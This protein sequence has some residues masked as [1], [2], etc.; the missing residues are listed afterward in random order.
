MGKG[1]GGRGLVLAWLG[2]AAALVLIGV[3]LAQAPGSGSVQPWHYSLLISAVLALALVLVLIILARR[4]IRQTENTEARLRAILESARDAIVIFDANRRIV[5]VNE[6]AERMFGYRREELIGQPAQLLVPEGY[7]EDHLSQ[8]MSWLASPGIAQSLD[9]PV[10]VPSQR[11]DGSRFPAEVSL[12]PAET[13]DGYVVTCIIRDVSERK[14]AA[15]ALRASEEHLRAVVETTPACIKIVAADGTLLDM[16]SAGLAMIDAERPEDVR[17]QCVYNLVAPEY[18]EAFRTLHQRVC[19]GE[20]GW[21]EF[22]VIGLRGSRRYMETHAVP[23]RGPGGASA[24]LAITYDITERKRAEEALCAS[25]E[26]YRDLFENANDIIYTHDLEGNFTSLNKAGEL[27]TGYTRAEILGRM[28]LR[29]IVAP[30][31]LPRALAMLED[32]L[33]HGRPSSRYEVTIVTKSGRRV[34]LEVSNR[35]IRQN[36]RPVGVQGIARDVTAQHLLEE[37]LRQSQK[38][39]AIGRLA[40][41]VAHDF[42]NLLTAIIGWS[43]LLLDD[44]PPDHPSRRLVEDISQAG[45]RAAALTQQLLGFSRKQVVAPTVLDLNAAVRD[46]QALLGRLIREDV[47]LS[48]DLAADIPPVQADPAQVQQV[49]LNLAVNARDAMPQGGR[50]TVATRAVRLGPSDRPGLAPGLY[51]VLSVSDTGHGMTEEVRAHLFEPFF[52]TKEKGKGTGLGLATVYGIV[53]GARGA[54]FV[55]TAV[56]RGTVFDIY[57]PAAPAGA[58]PTAAPAAPAAP[59]RGQET[60]LLVEDEQGVRQ[61]TRQALCL[62]GY[63]VLEASHP[64]EAL[65]IESEYD[66]PIHLLLTDVVMPGMNGRQLADRLVDLRPDLKVLYMS[67]YAD[68]AL[69]PDGT[70]GRELLAK[71]FTPAGLVRKVREVLDAGGRRGALAEATARAE[72]RPGS[73]AANGAKGTAG[74]GLI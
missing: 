47:E 51:A 62:Q 32:K 66:G 50:L 46:T 49:L 69:G 64:D 68:E 1:W 3:L 53:Q 8:S 15:D 44:M 42:N 5:L 61:L 23:L 73:P 7:L 17:G 37:R 21:L 28:N 18:R 29:D 20:R 27:V 74:A 45:R 2:A 55:E 67:G 34:T 56:G 39:E 19:R 54:I 58:G 40:G 35:V 52:T 4:R 30:E 22:E 63:T 26:R 10:E 38:M 6:Q 72:P 31:D 57:W 65:Q 13:P 36:G 70:L 71:P 11:R 33:R 25:E 60:I 41:G 43:D 48:A 14:R 24:Q 9:I 59:G 16:N 12:S